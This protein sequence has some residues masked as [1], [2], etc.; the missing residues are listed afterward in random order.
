[1]TQYDAKS[2]DPVYVITMAT[3]YD[4]AGGSKY[5]GLSNSVLGDVELS[6]TIRKNHAVLIGTADVPATNLAIG[7]ID[8]SAS[9]SKTIVRL[10][11][12]LDRR[13]ATG[14]APKADN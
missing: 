2:K 13:P 7:E 11:L 9:Q 6:D 8:Q 1:V 14:L 10:L 3:F 5:V 4:A 12:P